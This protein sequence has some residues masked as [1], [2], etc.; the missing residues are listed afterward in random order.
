MDESTQK[1][2]DSKRDDTVKPQ[3]ST[4][5]EQLVQ[6]SQ[7]EEAMER[8]YSGPFGWLPKIFRRN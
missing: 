7:A 1:N 5:G 4:E 3:I 8:D 2:S 6:A